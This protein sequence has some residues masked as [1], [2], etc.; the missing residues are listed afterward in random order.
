MILEDL[1]Q[2]FGRSSP[3]DQLKFVSEYRLKRATDLES[4]QSA[5]KTKTA[6][7][8]STNGL[9][10]TAEEKALMKMLGIKQKDIAALRA[11]KEIQEPL[12]LDDDK[13]GDI[14]KETMYEEEE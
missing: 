10:L 14:F 7:S 4:I 3:E 1:F 5:A 6:T 11:L 12:P 2:N 8:K 9:I 13:S